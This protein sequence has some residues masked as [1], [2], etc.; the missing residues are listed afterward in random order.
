MILPL[1][2]IYLLRCFICLSGWVLFIYT[3]IYPIL[4]EMAT[5]MP[6]ELPYRSHGNYLAERQ[7]FSFVQAGKC[8]TSTF[9]HSL[10]PENVQYHGDQLSREVSFSV[11]LFCSPLF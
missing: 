4:G 5:S 9:G 1:H 11:Q 8:E 2:G 7:G 3:L 6:D 10:V